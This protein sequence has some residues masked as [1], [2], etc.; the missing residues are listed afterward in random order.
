LALIL[1]RFEPVILMP[2]SSTG[3]VILARTPALGEVK[4][5]LASEIGTAA[6]LK[7]YQELLEITL[8]QAHRWI[9]LHPGNFAAVQLTSLD[10]S[11]PWLAS[12]QARFPKLHF[13]L[14]SHGELGERMVGAFRLALEH[15]DQAIIVGSDCPLLGPR[16]YTDVATALNDHDVAISPTEDGGF[17]L[18]GLKSLAAAQASGMF[19]RPRWSTSTTFE[20]TVG[21]ANAQGLHVKVLS[22]LWDVDTAQ[23]WTRWRE[24]V[25]SGQLPEHW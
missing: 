5:R 2:A 19:I 7:A 16:I 15:T 17:A 12:A 3:L 6:A 18:L 23:D 1:A 14:Q 9:D 11:N 4:T 24:L 21:C 20:D 25:A 13:S 10:F 22:K 8:T